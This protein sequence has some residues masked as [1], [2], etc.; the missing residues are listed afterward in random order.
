M[1]TNPVD[2]PSGIRHGYSS[3]DLSPIEVSLG[4][5]SM[6]GLKNATKQ[7]TGGEKPIKALYFRICDA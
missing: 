6:D 3:W 7:I 5:S 2:L 4:I 1:A